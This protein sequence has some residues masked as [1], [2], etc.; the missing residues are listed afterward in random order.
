MHR[1]TDRAESRISGSADLVKAMLV[2]GCEVLHDSSSFRDSCGGG[3]LWTVSVN[4][5]INTI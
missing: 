4:Q 1:R 5:S 3:F 2:G